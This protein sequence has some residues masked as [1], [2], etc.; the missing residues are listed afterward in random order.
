MKFY[1]SMGPNPRVVRMFLAE[2]NL[3][4]PFQDVDLMGA[5]N[6][7]AD[8]LAKN[9]FGQVPALELDDG[10]ILTEV[11]A[12]C[13]Y[14]DELNPGGNLMGSTAE[15]RA[16]T[17][18]WTRRVDL[19]V[20]EPMFAA[21]RAAEGRKLFEP[22]MRLVREEAAADLKAIAKDKLEILDKEMA[23]KSFLCGERFSFADIFFFGMLDFAAVVGQPLDE[24]FA[25]LGAWKDRVGERPSAAASQ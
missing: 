13:E 23:G 17:R 12:I 24:Q 1:N 19:Y 3:E 18:M 14:L 8:Y 21:F 20:V 6:R 5:E 2:K 9:P 10:S 11:T 25:N 7:Q 15:E 4:I 22:R 16:E